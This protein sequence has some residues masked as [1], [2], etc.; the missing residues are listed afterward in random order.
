M[1]YEIEKNILLY[2]EEPSINIILT[3]FFS[4]KD[5][6]IYE[7]KSDY[8]FKEKIKDNFHTIIIEEKELKNNI[9]FIDDFLT[10][11]NGLFILIS[12]ENYIISNK[13][14]RLKKPLNLKELEYIISN[15]YKNR[16]NQKNNYI[17]KF[18]SENISKDNNKVLFSILKLNEKNIALIY[19][20]NNK[21]VHAEYNDLIGE[22]AWEEII[23]IQDGLLA[24][25]NNIETP[26]IT[27]D[28]DTE[29]K[30]N[31]IDVKNINNSL[32]EYISNK[33]EKEEEIK[34]S[35]IHITVV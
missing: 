27:C 9:Q 12:N 15:Y 11:F 8:E 28:I 31:T 16:N 3:R 20:E 22:E 5:Y 2:T 23:N 10:S 17:Y 25:Y 7:S 1:S 34:N 19:T 29:L 24:F 21:I 26:L 13:I 14:I 33:I 35:Y 18:I 30:N 4:K 6:F 32:K